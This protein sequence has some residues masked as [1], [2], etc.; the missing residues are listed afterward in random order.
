ME[1]EASRRAHNLIWQNF[2]IV[3]CSCGRQLGDRE[4]FDRHLQERMGETSSDE[5]RA[6]LRSVLAN[7]K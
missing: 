2:A 3:G 1:S 5:G 7:E 6:T 4:Q